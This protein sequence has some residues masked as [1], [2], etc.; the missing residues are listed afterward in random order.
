M[1]TGQMLWEGSP[2][3][4]RF[5][6]L[7]SVLPTVVSYQGALTLK[8]VEE[9]MKEG[10]RAAAV[11]RA[12]AIPLSPE[13][14]KT[15]GV[16]TYGDVVNAFGDDAPRILDFQATMENRKEMALMRKDQQA[17]YKTSNMQAQHAKVS[18]QF[19]DL[20]AKLITSDDIL[21]K[22]NQGMDQ[23]AIDSWVRNE[24]LIN[25][26]RM[27]TAEDYSTLQGYNTLLRN[28]ETGLGWE[29]TGAK[30]PENVMDAATML[31]QLEKQRAAEKKL[32]DEHKKELMLKMLPNINDL[33]IG[34]GGGT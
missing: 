22:V 16:K 14:Q 26:K 21:D 29:A 13:L 6:L 3:G 15:F 10:R 27:A 19:S 8:Q 20:R 2:Q 18:K 34:L 28:I 4:R 32:L 12:S 9:D 1:K 24:T 31:E 33:G 5:A 25:G 23:K 30:A 11:S 17:F 7:R